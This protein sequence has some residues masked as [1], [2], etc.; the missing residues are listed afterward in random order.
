MVKINNIELSLLVEAVRVWTGWG[1]DVMP[2]RDDSL[3]VEHFGAEVAAK[4][5]PII[6]SL[7]DDFYLSDARFVAD[8]LQ[9]MEKLSSEQFRKKHPAVADEIVRAFAWCY[10]FDFK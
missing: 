1:R 8:D 6:K 2:R 4:L 10:T 5:L 3:L 9:E 7:Q